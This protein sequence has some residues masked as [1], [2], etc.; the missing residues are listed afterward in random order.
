MK[1]HPNVRVSMEGMDSLEK[2]LRRL[3]DAVRAQK[4][5]RSVSAG[6]DVL[7]EFMQ[8]LAPRGS[9]GQPHAY[10]FIR[11]ER[12]EDSRPEHVDYAVG[13]T[14]AG[15]YLT[16]HETGTLHMAPSP[17]MRPAMEAGRSVILDAVADQLRRELSLIA[18]SRV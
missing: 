17:F 16:F 12:T 8:A 13:P 11:A 3:P 6:A 15:F 1:G 2:K 18:R 9:D 14:G 7:V 10:Q 4:L 5:D